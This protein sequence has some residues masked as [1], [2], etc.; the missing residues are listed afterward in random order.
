MKKLPCPYRQTLQTPQTQQTSQI[1]GEGVESDVCGSVGGSGS[2]NGGKSSSKRGVVVGSSKE[3][4]VDAATLSAV[5]AVTHGFV[6]ADLQLLCSEAV[7]IAARRLFSS[8]TSTSTSTS[9]PSSTPTDSSSGL[10]VTSSDLLAATKRIRPSALREVSIEVIGWLVGWLIVS[11][12]VFFFLL[13]SFLAQFDCLS[14]L[15]GN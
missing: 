14:S 12:S 5:A 11:P 6:G 4:C 13:D 2:E 3:E 7:L 1:V 9:T 8:S 15:L 10:V